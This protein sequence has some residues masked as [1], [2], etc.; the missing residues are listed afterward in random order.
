MESEAQPEA[1]AVEAD[2]PIVRR[3]ARLA[4]FEIQPAERGILSGVQQDRRR[5][6][7]NGRSERRYGEESRRRAV[8]AQALH[9]CAGNSGGSQANA[10]KRLTPN[11]MGRSR[12]RGKKR[13]R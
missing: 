12:L 9:V 10:K 8:S 13:G 11:E 1:R 7:L 5:S 6:W 2:A 4:F 3:R